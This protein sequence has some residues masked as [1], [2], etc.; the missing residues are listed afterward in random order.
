MSDTPI[1]E[2]HTRVQLHTVS[3]GCSPTLLWRGALSSLLAQLEDHPDELV[4]LWRRHD[5][6]QF[7]C[8]VWFR[9]AAVEAVWEEESL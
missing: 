6:E 4:C 7:V 8:P 5:G 3:G 2:L 1:P 9:P